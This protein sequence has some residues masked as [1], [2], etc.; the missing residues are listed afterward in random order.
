MK[1]LIILLI[2]PCTLFSVVELRSQ[3]KTNTNS[4]LIER[5]AAVNLVGKV[6]HGSVNFHQ[7]DKNSP[8]HVT[9]TLQGLSPGLYGFH[10][11]Q[12]GDISK[13]DCMGT[14]AHFNPKKVSHGAPSDFIRHVGDYSIIG[15]GLVV[16]E[17]ADDLGKG[18]KPDSLT[19]GSA[20][21][22]VACGVIGVK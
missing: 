6:V 18:N 16:H 8:V 5:S 3:T 20:G 17:R 1:N 12:D 19:T 13:A 22:R 10:V 2:L 7:D 4:E 14:G 21:A 11:H 15:R 9:G